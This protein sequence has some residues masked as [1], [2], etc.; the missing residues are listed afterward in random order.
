ML[1]K[2]TGETA[3]VVTGVTACAIGDLVTFTAHEVGVFACSGE[4]DLGCAI[5]RRLFLRAQAVQA[6]GAHVG[7]LRQ[8]CLIKLHH[9]TGFDHAV[10]VIVLFG[11]LAQRGALRD[12]DHRL[13]G[14]GNHIAFAPDGHGFLAVATRCNAFVAVERRHVRAIERPQRA[15]HMRPLALGDGEVSGGVE[16][17]F[18]AVQGRFAQQHR[19][20]A[21]GFNLMDIKVATVREV[22]DRG[23]SLGVTG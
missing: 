9:A 6:V 13:K 14:C 2:A 7:H 11:V 23:C 18:I 10:D 16:R 15:L 20:G 12:V 19:A 17:Q 5:R 22:D 4:V 21:A 8:G 1:L 3:C